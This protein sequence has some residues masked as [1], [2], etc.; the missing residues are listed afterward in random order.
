MTS[1]DDS[2]VHFRVVRYMHEAG[3]KLHLESVPLATAATI[4]H[5]FFKQSSLDD[6]DPYLIGAACISLACKV[7]EKAIRLRD[8]VNVCYRTL[9]KNKAP[10]E[11]GETFWALRESIASLELFVLRALQFKVVYPNP[12]KYL[13]HYLQALADWFDPH[14]WAEV[15]VGRS[16]WA[17]LRDSYHSPVACDVAP[18]HLAVAVL[19]LALQAH[20]M[21]VPGH[22]YA[23]HKWWQVFSSDISL[24]KIEKIT[25]DIMDMYSTEAQLTPAAPR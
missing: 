25:G 21:D 3:L 2:T 12:H 17:L 4:Y 20:G 5:K 24:E 22:K 7:E 16:A 23:R 15:P 6:F 10:L 18:E 13:V 1:S 19:Y 14:V 11:I 8:I 9:H